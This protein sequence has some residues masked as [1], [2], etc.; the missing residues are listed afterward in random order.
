[1]CI[2]GEEVG[3]WSQG[4]PPGYNESRVSFDFL[5]KSLLQK[6]NYDW[7]PNGVCR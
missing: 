7:V 5:Q 6:H 1:M 4:N 2:S 3:S